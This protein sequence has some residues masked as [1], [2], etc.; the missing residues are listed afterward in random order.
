MLARALHLH[1]V[2]FCLLS[3]INVT[4]GALALCL[5]CASIN[6]C[7]SFSN[8]I[9]R[10]FMPAI[11]QNSLVW[12]LLTFSTSSSIT[13]IWNA[14][15]GNLEHPHLLLAGA[16]LVCNCIVVCCGFVSAVGRVS[17]FA[18]LRLLFGRGKARGVTACIS[19]HCLCYASG[20]LHP[21]VPPAA[22][23][24]WAVAEVVLAAV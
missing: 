7:Y 10:E 1:R 12:L 3:C 11:D 2:F 17:L 9:H 6:Q 18:F 22:V 21:P 4:V 8:E 16:L 19:M 15:D 24:E 23:L 5:C 20:T 14:V 13:T